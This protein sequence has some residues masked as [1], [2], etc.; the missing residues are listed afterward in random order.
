MKKINYFY[1]YN[2]QEKPK[3]RS[4]ILRGIIGTIL[5]CIAMTVTAADSGLQ[6]QLV[7]GD[8]GNHV[9][10]ITAAAADSLL[11]QKLK[12]YD[13]KGKNIL[14]IVGFELFYA[15]RGLFEDSTG[16]PMI[17]T[18]YYHTQAAADTVPQYFLTS[19]KDLYKAGDTIKIQNIFSKKGDKFIAVNNQ[20]I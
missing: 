12:A 7:F 17:M 3:M 10:T 15:E 19:L 4:S 20:I 8:K 16:R 9:T 18:E 13:V 1:K 14:P 11:H 2:I 6:Y 5:A